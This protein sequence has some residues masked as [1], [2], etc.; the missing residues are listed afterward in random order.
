MITRLKDAGVTTVVLFT[1]LSMNL[2]LLTQANQQEYHPEWL[3]TGFLF[4]EI[5]PISRL[6]NQEQWAH[7]FGLGTLNVPIAGRPAGEPLLAW[8]WGDR[9]FSYNAGTFGEMVVLKFGMHLA[10]PKLTP[11]NFRKAVFGVGAHGGAPN[12]DPGNI[13]LARGKAP[14]VPYT[15][16]LFG[17]DHTLVWWNPDAMLTDR[18]DRAPP[19][20]VDVPRGREALPAGEVAEGRAE[21]LR[22]VGV[23]GRAARRAEAAARL[24]VRRVPEHRERRAT[25]GVAPG[26]SLSGGR[27][28]PTA[29]S[30]RPSPAGS[31]TRGRPESTATRSW[32]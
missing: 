28:R 5:P 3:Q 20:C 13:M 8:Y 23:G 4:S 26:G 9:N 30:P 21:V 31:R 29:P 15:E 6:M 1:D 10:G 2:A 17:G 14:G 27:R 16:Y 22:R 24:A 19:R 32:P 7:T 25:R 12:D 11:E 18:G